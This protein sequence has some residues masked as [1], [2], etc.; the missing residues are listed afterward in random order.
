MFTEFIA[1]KKKK[2]IKLINQRIR[3]NFRNASH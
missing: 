1:I 3:E 2:K